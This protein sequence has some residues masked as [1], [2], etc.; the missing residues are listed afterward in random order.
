MI[1][2][3]KK[4]KRQINRLLAVQFIYMYDINP[5]SNFEKFIYYQNLQIKKFKFASNII[6][7]LIKNLKKID[8]IIIKHLLNWKF[9]RL[10]NVDKAILRV[11]IYEILYRKDI[12]NIV[13]INEAINL[14]KLLSEKNSKGFINGIL[15]SINK[16]IIT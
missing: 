2:L 14:S 9:Y 11:A 3:K 4:G 7:K 13:S 10:L 16:S 5:E 1:S 15:D 6:E 12:P 8:K